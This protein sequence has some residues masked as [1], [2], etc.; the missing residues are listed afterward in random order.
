VKRETR[1]RDAHLVVLRRFR[2]DFQGQ[3]FVEKVSVGQL[4]FSRLFQT[5]GQCLLDLIEPQVMTM[6]LQSFQLRGALWR[7]PLSL[8]L[9][10]SYSARSRTITSLS[11]PKWGPKRDAGGAPILGPR[12]AVR[13]SAR[14]PSSRCGG[15]LR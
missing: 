8:W 5:R 4:P 13:H 12:A 7:S 10:A 3:Q 15:G 6:L 2:A 1:H 14:V 9:A 11:R